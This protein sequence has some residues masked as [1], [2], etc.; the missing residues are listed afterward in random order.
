MFILAMILNSLAS[1]YNHQTFDKRIGWK[2]KS[3]KQ[4][5]ICD[6]SKVEV[7]HIKKAIKF[8]NDHY[9]ELKT[10]EIKKDTCEDISNYSK[11]NIVI[12]KNKSFSVKQYYAMT[13][14]D[15]AK[16]YM[17]QQ[18]DSVRI[19]VNTAYANNEKMII[20]EIGHSIGVLHTNYDETHIM[21]MHVVDNENVRTN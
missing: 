4:I 3:P 5:I 20:H 16:P 8:W 6:N 7:S 18:I 13:Y 21:H 2:N 9:D 10:V 1:T 17:Y 12:M 19:E 14:Y 15:F 11:G